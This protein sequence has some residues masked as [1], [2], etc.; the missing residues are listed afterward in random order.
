MKNKKTIIIS[1]STI[2]VILISAISYI[3][4]SESNEKI[5][6]PSKTIFSKYNG[7][8]ITLREAQNELGKLI[9]RNDK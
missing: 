4:L 9:L 8:E 7:E 3:L 6:N 2:S 1:I 5:A